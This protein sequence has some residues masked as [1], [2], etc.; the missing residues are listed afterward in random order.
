MPNLRIVVTMLAGVPVLALAGGLP[1]NAEG[2]RAPVPV[3]ASGVASGAGCDILIL[4]YTYRTEIDEKASQVRVKGAPNWSYLHGNRV[5]RL[6][7]FTVGPA[8][9]IATNGVTWNWKQ[10]LKQE[11]CDLNRR[12]RFRVRGLDE[13]VTGNSNE[14]Y[15]G[16]ERW[17]YFPSESGW[18]Q[19]TRL[20]LGYTDLCLM[21]GTKC[22]K[23]YYPSGKSTPILRKEEIVWS[24]W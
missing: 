6:P 4:W 17:L 2:S 15:V 10:E 14:P 21:D 24:S 1:G 7:S 11:R 12:Y 23:P 13:M 8:P 18:T 22:G 5:E 16:T 9:Y 3:T 19:R 20:D